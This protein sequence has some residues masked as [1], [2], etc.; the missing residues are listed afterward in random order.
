MAPRLDSCG[1]SINRSKLRV[2][3]GD[4]SLKF[5]YQQKAI[6]DQQSNKSWLFSG[7]DRATVMTAPV[8]TCKL[9]DIDPQAWLVD[10]LARRTAA[11]ELERPCPVCRAASGSLTR[12]YS[13]LARDDG[14]KVKRSR[15]F[16]ASLL[17]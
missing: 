10:V 3:D 1:W 7:A 8:I 6:K 9:N 2:A 14:L 12:N 11:M 15:P 13:P 17:P 16:R 4:F 5:S